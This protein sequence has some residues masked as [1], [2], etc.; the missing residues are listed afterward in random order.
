MALCDTPFAFIIRLTKLI[1]EV[2]EKTKEKFNKNYDVFHSFLVE[3]AD[4]EGRYEM[5]KIIQIHTNILFGGTKFVYIWKSI[6]R[7]ER[8]ARIYKGLQSV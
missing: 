7:R 5:P 8:M 4:Y 6:S 2:S 3:N 1:M